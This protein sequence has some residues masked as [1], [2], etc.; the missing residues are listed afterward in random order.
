MTDRSPQM[1]DDLR[2]CHGRLNACAPTRCGLDSAQT[3]AATQAW[4]HERQREQEDRCQAFELAEAHT[5]FNS[6]L[7]DVDE[8]SPTGT[9]PSVDYERSG[10]GTIDLIRAQVIVARWETRL[11]SHDRSKQ[12]S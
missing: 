9:Q 7:R 3:M 10:I 2:D 4:L 11:P 5:V 6:P 12:E 1:L 8:R